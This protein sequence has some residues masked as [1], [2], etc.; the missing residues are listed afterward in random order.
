MKNIILSKRSLLPE[1]ASRA[2]KWHWNY[3]LHGRGRPLLAGMYI[4]N[5]C[6][7]ACRNCNI[8]R[9]T[10]KQTISRHQYN[11]LV[12]SLGEMGGFYF[13]ISG[14][15]PL[16]VSDICDRL[17]YAK[18][19]I[20]YVHLVSNGW[21]LDAEKAV[22]L[23]D[24]GVD[25]VSIS[26]DGLE[27]FHD[28]Q[29]GRIGSY[30][31]AFDAVKNMKRFA[32]NVVV[33]V[34]SIITP[35]NAN[36]IYHL[37]NSTG[38]LGV[39]HKVQPLNLHPI[40]S[41]QSSESVGVSASEEQIRNVV[42]LV[43]FMKDQDHVVNS[44]KF[45]DSIVPHFRGECSGGVFEEDCLLPE[46]F[47][48]FRQDGAVSPCLAASG[49]KVAF[50]TAGKELNTVFGSIE[51]AAYKKSLRECRECKKNAYVCYLEPRLIFPLPVLLKNKMEAPK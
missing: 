6:N 16:L 9:D 29:R 42:D 22:E 25:E 45:L 43:D 11:S 39:F 26:I 36:D 35:E 50:P 51:Y 1:L 37:I 15:E 8:W 17:A 27:A 14:G 38:R 13:S 4:T 5:E 32:P 12:S 31:R 48:E 19:H 20:P 23:S 41:N 24:S 33:S 3:Y 47:C 28:A 30:K 21:L 10:K 2:S 18:K 44:A 7:L 40:F 46:F 34:N 49:W